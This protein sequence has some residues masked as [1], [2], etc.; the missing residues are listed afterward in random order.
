MMSLSDPVIDWVKLASG[1]GVEAARA[2]SVRTLDDLV[3]TGISRQGPFLIEAV[4]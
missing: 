2:D 4:L 1:L 3:R